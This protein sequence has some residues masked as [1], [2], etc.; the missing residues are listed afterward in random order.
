[1]WHICGWMCFV[2]VTLTVAI[3]SIQNMRFENER[4]L[5]EN[6]YHCA[7]LPYQYIIEVSRTIMNVS[8]FKETLK[9]KTLNGKH[10]ELSIVMI[11]V[12]TQTI[13]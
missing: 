4:I 13:W 7:Y 6:E 10:S 1:M 2:V 8:W 9:W 11:I 3:T 5:P 12:L